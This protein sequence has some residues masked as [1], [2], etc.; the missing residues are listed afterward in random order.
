MGRPIV[1]YFGAHDGLQGIKDL[2]SAFIVDGSWVLLDLLQLHF[3]ALCNKIEQVP[4]ATNASTEDTLIWMPSSIGDLR[5][6]HAYQFL[7]HPSPSMPWGKSLWSRFILPRMSLHAWKVLKGRIICDELLQRLG[8]TWVSRCEFCG[9]C[10]ESLQHIFLHCPFT[11]AIWSYFLSLF[12]MGVTPHTIV[13][14]FHKGLSMGRSSQLKELWLI[15]FTSILWFVWHARNKT[16][17][18]GKSFSVASTC[19]LILGHIRAASRR[20]NGPMHNSVQDLRIIKSFGA[21]CRLGRAP[22]V[23]KVVWHPPVIGWVKVNSDGAWKH[24]EGVGG[25][26]AVFRDFKGHVLG[27]FSSNIDIPSSVAAEV[28]S[29]IVAI[30][31]AWARDWKHIWLE[32]DSSLVLDY[33]QSSL[34]VPWNL[35][36]RWLN[37]LRCISEMTFRSSHIFREGNKVADAL[38]NH[39]KINQWHHKE[40][41][42]SVGYHVISGG[43]SPRLARAGAQIP[44]SLQ[45]IAIRLIRKRLTLR[46]PVA[47]SSSACCAAPCLRLMRCIVPSPTALLLPSTYCAAPPLRLLRCSAPPPARLSQLAALLRG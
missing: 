28:M 46:S 37:C 8:V 25:F 21:E 27:V 47:C 2:V 6:K 22:R 44:K 4:L 33:L 5:A 16:R 19:H 7:R 13:D 32:V 18:D 31:L 11:A 42:Q 29:V 30:E 26:G 9:A 43:S 10:T 34:L 17:F 12:D 3:P 38:A 1:D 40:N 39:G 35:R 24:A 14:L 15:Y 36:V 45:P 23:I 41:A 20:A